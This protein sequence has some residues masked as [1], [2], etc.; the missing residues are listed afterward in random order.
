MN[1]ATFLDAE[2]GKLITIKLDEYERANDSDAL[3]KQS[4]ILKI[5]T[6]AKVV[7]G[8]AAAV[9]VGCC[10]ASAVRVSW[11]PFL[12]SLGIFVATGA[13]LAAFY[14]T[15]N[16]TEIYSYEVL[17]RIK[18]NWGSSSVNQELRLLIIDAEGYHKEFKR[19]NEQDSYNPFKK[20]M[21]VLSLDLK[22]DSYKI[23]QFLGIPFEEIHQ[24]LLS[25]SSRVEQEMR[26]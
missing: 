14:R 10:I 8:I 17:K 24:H 3:Q 2:I 9:F 1:A 16:I 20:W 4:L 13:I 19:M 21:N 22:S 15:M 11:V 7:S 5:F 25:L 6:V 23:A 18:D 26:V 12:P